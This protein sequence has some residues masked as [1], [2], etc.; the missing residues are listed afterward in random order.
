MFGANDDGQ[1]GLIHTININIPTLPT[2]SKSMKIITVACGGNH[3]MV[4]T[5]SGE[6]FAFGWN[7]YG[8]LGLGV[9]TKKVTTPTLVTLPS[10][11]PIIQ[12][13]NSNSNE[14]IFNK[15]IEL[16]QSTFV[17]AYRYV[18]DDGFVGLVFCEIK[19]G[20]ATEVV[21]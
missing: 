10:Q 5:D 12:F 9:D 16:Y 14:F 20:H 3:T 18:I 17:V 15:N 21:L 2:T 13:W 8:Q 4:L 11:Q 7:G 19:K 1:L 6:T